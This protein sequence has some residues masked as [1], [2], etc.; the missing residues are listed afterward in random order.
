M[1]IRSRPAWA[2]GLKQIIQQMTLNV[3]FVAPRVGAWIETLFSGCIIN[4][5]ESRPAWARGL[6][7]LC[8]RGYRKSV[9]VA[10]RVGA[11]IET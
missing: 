7:H 10:P 6:K 11:W 8:G 1:I 4:A 5:P 9:L 3:Y 2:R